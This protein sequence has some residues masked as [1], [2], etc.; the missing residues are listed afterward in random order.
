MPVCKRP[1][2]IRV[3]QTSFRPRRRRPGQRSL[4]RRDGRFNGQ[5]GR[6]RRQGPKK[7]VKHGWS[8][9]F[10]LKSL[11][12]YSYCLEISQS[13]D[14]SLDWRP[15][16]LLKWLCLFWFFFA[17]RF[18]FTWTEPSRPITLIRRSW[19]LPWRGVSRDAGGTVCAKFD[20][21]KPGTKWRWRMSPG[22]ILEMGCLWE[23]IPPNMACLRG[24]T[25]D[26]YETSRFGMSYF[27]TQNRMAWIYVYAHV[28]DVYNFARQPCTAAQ[29]TLGI[30][31]TGLAR[32]ASGEAYGV[33]KDRREKLLQ[34]GQ[35]AWVAWQLSW[36]SFRGISW[37]K[38]GIEGCDRKDSGAKTRI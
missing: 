23:G 37:R 34:L 7:D 2:G 8:S 29:V 33:R 31:L 19:G 4:L 32:C 15:I 36:P 26:E 30:Y 3:P 16:F 20:S 1:Q 35:D 12:S 14:I 11:L 5:K 13:E 10:Q 22:P 9:R 27:V 38:I 17:W 6:R 28:Y 25:D 24:N 18:C 21:C